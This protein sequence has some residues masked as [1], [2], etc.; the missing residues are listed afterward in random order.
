MLCMV[1]GAVL[2]GLLGLSVE[3]LPDDIA[4]PATRP[5]KLSGNPLQLTKAHGMERAHES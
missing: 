2:E 3:G 1:M 5:R 4:P